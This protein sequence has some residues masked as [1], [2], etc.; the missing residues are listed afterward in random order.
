[1]ATLGVAMIVKDESANVANAINSIKNFVDQIVV[2]DTGSTDETPLIC[3]R[4]GAEV[5]FKKWNEDFSEARN[6]AISH[7]RTDWI[8]SIDADEVFDTTTFEK[9]RPFLEERSIGGLNVKIIN[10]LGERD[11]SPQSEHR[12]TR[13]YRNVP[14]I[15]Y[16]GR[17]HEQILSSIYDLGLEVPE[18]DIIIKHYGYVDTSEEKK[19]RNKELLEQEIMEHPEDNWLKFHLAE[20]E[21]ALGNIDKAKDLYRFVAN[22]FGLSIEQVERTRIRLAQIGLA[23]DDFESIQEW[24][25]FKSNDIHRDG[26]RK[27]I[28]AAGC[29]TNNQFS[30]AL[31]LFQSV[32]VEGSNLVDK[33]R[34]TDAI[35]ALKSFPGI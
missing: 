32:E 28:L 26:L 10:S 30:A 16:R 1:M 31:E 12:Y 11:F 3:T 21:F 2:V 29:M 27:F 5:Y 4:L 8:I 13:I 33:T 34:V 14:G 18:T 24:C 23:Q 20:T 25:D 9:Y 35:R 22:T 17:I 6:F 7:V 15:A 19:M